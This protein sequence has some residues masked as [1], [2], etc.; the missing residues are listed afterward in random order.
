MQLKQWLHKAK[1]ALQQVDLPE[2]DAH[3]LLCR[4]LKVDRAYLF[5]H[6]DDVL[7]ALMLAELDEWLQKRCADMPLAYICGRVEFYGTE[8]L[9]KQ[10]VLIPRPDTE[11][12]L[13]IIQ[14]EWQKRDEPISILELAGGSGALGLSMAKIYENATL[15]LGDISDDAC[16][17]MQE[18]TDSL[19][20]SER[21]KI[22]KSDWL[23]DIPT[24]CFNCVLVNPPYIARDAIQGLD[25]NVRDYE[26]H[27]ALDGGFDGLDCYR[28]INQQLPDFMDKNGRL[29][30]EIGANQGDDVISSMKNFTFIRGQEDLGQILRGLVFKKK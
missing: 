4:Y 30:V 12:L 10:G 22:I 16:L 23:E 15:I 19:K 9:I 17:L 11:I 13:D 21:V 29:I 8:F 27:L 6:E 3:Y 2:R 20:L 18:N 7:D 24:S 25:K 1:D 5:T 14:A 26:P 28:A